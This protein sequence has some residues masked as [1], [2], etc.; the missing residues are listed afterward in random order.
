[1]SDYTRNRTVVRDGLARL[2][3]QYAGVPERA[4]GGGRGAISM[5]GSLALSTLAPLP[6]IANLRFLHPVDT[7]D[8]SGNTLID[9]SGNG[10]NATVLNGPATAVASGSIGQALN[11]TQ[12]NKRITINAGAVNS[13]WTS[14][15]SSFTYVCHVKGITGA[16]SPVSILG[17]VSTNPGLVGVFNVWIGLDGAVNVDY[18]NAN[19]G[20][21]V[22][23]VAAPAGTVDLSVFSTIVVVMYP[24]SAGRRFVIGVNSE[25]VS[26]HTTATWAG[27]QN[28]ESS[29]PLI[30][31][32]GVDLT[33]G[34]I[35][36]EMAFWNTT[37]DEA[38][39]GMAH[40]LRI[41]NTSIRTHLGL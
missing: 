1:V 12:T 7:A 39:I 10:W 30:G 17:G 15:A 3:K 31:Q 26:D 9:R 18:W 6:S 25:V 35:F 38:Q 37:A 4:L 40:A 24:Y 36:D 23:Y 34:G 2:L 21:D 8:V 16:T 5:S 19:E 29:T 27:T 28:P 11:T 20:Y 41:S 33:Y 14:K 13:G 32:R 22:G